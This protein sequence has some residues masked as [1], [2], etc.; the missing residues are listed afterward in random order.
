MIS[1]NLGQIAEAIAVIFPALW[2]RD[3]SVQ[4]TPRTC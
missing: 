2:V 1:E 4:P 3:R